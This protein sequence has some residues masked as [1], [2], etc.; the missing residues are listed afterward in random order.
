MSDRQLKKSITLVQG[1][2]ISVGAVIGSG[3]LILPAITAEEAGPAAIISWIV[4]S[5]LALPLALTLGRLATKV[6]NAGG[7]A[8]YV[9]T[10]FGPQAGHLTGWLFLGTIP[11]GAPI[12]AL[13][14]A[15]YVGSVFHLSNWAIT[16]L[17]ALMM[18][19]S[20]LLNARGVEIAAW[21]QVLIVCLIIVLLVLAVVVASPHIQ[22]TAFHP[23]IPHGWSAVA[24]A[25]MTIFWSFAGWEMVA[26]LAE[27][28]RNPDRDILVSLALGA[29][30]ISFLYV[31][32]EFVTIGT[33]SYGLS[34]GMAPLA[35]LFDKAFGR[36]AFD[37]TAFLALLITFGTI[38]TNIAGFSRMVYAQAREGDFPEYFAKLHPRYQT[39]FIALGGMTAVFMIVLLVNGVFHP[40]LG[41]FMQWVSV[42]FLVL[43][44]MA[45]ASALKLLPRSDFGW[46][47]AIIPLVVC[48]ILYPFSGWA[49][50][51]PPTL[52]GIGWVFSYRLKR[53]K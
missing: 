35:M 8:A 43:Y 13:V 30:V 48:A 42:V 26:H 7:I 49:A 16:G 2:A 15:N 25:S 3:I 50:I 31:A 17:A 1:T 29:L 52:L 22:Y 53:G 45:M 47:L 5:I 36:V 44:M 11:I 38:H 27:E 6:P 33:Q 24:V 32:I 39:P 37:S 9:R 34:I 21:I 28:F 20:V 19:T 10:A 41:L 14:G 23:F 4:M 46:W 12:A 40:N 18:I 51:Y